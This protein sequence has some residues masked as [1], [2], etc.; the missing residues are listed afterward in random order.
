MK[1]VAAACEGTCEGAAW[2]WLP[3]L[4]LDVDMFWLA[5]LAMLPNK[6]LALVF[7]V[8]VAEEE[9]MLALD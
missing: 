9:A 8:R 7:G 4:K 6:L 3:K 5:L 1:G 2:P